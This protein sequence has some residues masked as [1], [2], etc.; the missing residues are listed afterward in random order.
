MTSYLPPLPPIVGIC[1]PARAGKDTLARVLIGMG[2]VKDSFAAPIRN[3]VAQLCGLTLDQLELVKDFPSDALAGKTPR[4]AMQTLGTEW[5]RKLI[6]QDL[7][8][9]YLM[10][11]ATGQRLVVPDIRFENEAQ[12]I[13]KQGGIILKVVRPGVEIVE[14]THASEAGIPDSLVDHTFVNDKGVKEL[15]HAVVDLLYCHFGGE[16]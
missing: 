1:G 9:N 14:S 16:V 3:Y 10:R 12:A 4:Y 6:A 8:I 13:I 11:R 7:W 2:Y 15:G 5:G